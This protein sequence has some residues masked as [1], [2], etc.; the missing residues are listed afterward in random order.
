MTYSNIHS[1]S[2]LEE[3]SPFPRITIGITCYNAA[4]SIQRALHSALDQNWPDFEVV[5]VDDASSDTS[6]LLIEQVSDGDSRIRPVYHQ[7]NL[8]AAAARNSILEA[9]SGE[10]IAFFDDDDV[11]TPD[12]LQLQYERIVSYEQT[13]STQLIACYASGERMYPN[14]YVMPLRAVGAD[15]QPP[16]GSAMADYLLF[17]KREPGIF[18]GAGTPTCSLMARTSVF[19]EIGGFDTAMRRQEDID[20][21]IR[22]SFKEGHFIGI[23][24]EVL[25]QHATY[26]SEKNALVEFESFLRL[27]DKNKDYLFST[28]SYCYM[29]LWS[30]MRYRHFSGQDGQALLILTKLLLSSP[31]RTTQHFLGSATRRFLHERSIGAP[32]HD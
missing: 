22:L 3:S 4:H 31:W 24:E 16:I 17:Y 19:Q 2:T 21:A 8:G 23:S 14:G 9:A 29:K 15:G 1:N 11:S 10:F 27:L 18:Y 7:V 30:E 20:F 28:D 6:C 13:A 12:R 5:V 32:S 25:M 26:G